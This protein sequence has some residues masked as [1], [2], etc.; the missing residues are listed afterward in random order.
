M[1]KARSVAALAILVALLSIGAPI[2]RGALPLVPGTPVF[3]VLAL[4]P[5]FAVAARLAI[6]PPPP[7][8]LDLRPVQVHRFEI[9]HRDLDDMVRDWIGRDVTFYFGANLA[10][11]D[12]SWVKTF[13]LKFYV[14]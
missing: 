2:A 12:V 3:A 6:Q 13:G 7:S 4:R 5:V 8:Y 9:P 11:G 1:P 10:S 14:K